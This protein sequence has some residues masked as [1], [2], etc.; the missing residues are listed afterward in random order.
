[1]TFYDILGVPR[2]ATQEEIRS[3]Y[4]ALARRYHPDGLNGSD[5]AEREAAEEN[6]K[7][8]NAAFQTLGDPGKRDDYHTVM[9]TRRDPARHFRFR[10]PAH[11][12]PFPDVNGTH[13]N[14]AHHTQPKSAEAKA[15]Y[16]ELIKTRGEKDYW[17]ERN[18]VRRRRL[19]M[20]AGFTSLVVYFLVAFGTQ[21]Y[22]GFDELLSLTLYFIG[23]EL[24]AMPI[25]LNASGTRLN[26]F[27]FVG[28]P[29][30]F[31]VTVTLGTIVTC[32]SIPNIELGLSTPNSLYSGTVISTALLVHLFLAT[33][34]GRIQ[35]HAF[36][37][38]LLKIERRLAE[39][40]QHLH[41]LKRYR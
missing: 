3:A 35:D 33:R 22:S 2:S 12:R 40:E 16:L 21:I 7:A 19:W 14:G 36:A 32:S 17:I 26:R 13:K 37:A 18:G 39:L 27:P 30:A 25:I 4:R 34:L 29:V 23:V 28:S 31:S 6:I 24:I 8:I 9:W 20:S 15:L 10:R 38:R 41:D 11:D 5:A 1:M